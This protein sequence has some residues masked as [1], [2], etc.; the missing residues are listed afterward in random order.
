MFGPRR[1]HQYIPNCI[2][3]SVLAF[4]L[5]KQPAAASSPNLD[6]WNGS[7]SCNGPLIGSTRVVLDG[8]L[9]PHH[10]TD[11]VGLLYIGGFTRFPLISLSFQLFTFFNF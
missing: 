9:T 7:T 8:D 6:R 3:S 11:F 1:L 10:K 2:S 5:K 4:G